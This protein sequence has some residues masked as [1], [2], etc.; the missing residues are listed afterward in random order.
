MVDGA[1]WIMAYK[2]T[3]GKLKIEN[4][5]N[6]NSI[7][8]PDLAEIKI[9]SSKTDIEKSWAM[10]GQNIATCKHEKLKF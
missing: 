10:K 8:G 6:H 9:D 5:Q 4:G 2:C 1:A 3:L 7:K